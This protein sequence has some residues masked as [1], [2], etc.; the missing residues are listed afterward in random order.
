MLVY[1]RVTLDDHQFFSDDHWTDPKVHES[2]Q[3]IA[4]SHE[5]SPQMV[6]LVRTIPLFQGNLGW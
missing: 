5:F 3:I 1:W 2:S 4:T 6:G